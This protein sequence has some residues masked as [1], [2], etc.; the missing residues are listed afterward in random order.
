[1]RTVIGEYLCVNCKNN[2]TGRGSGQTA[3]R[4]V[5]R[6]RPFDNDERRRVADSKT[7]RNLSKGS[8]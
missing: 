7:N 1:M 8:S 3:A 6:D 5:S 2:D 4:G